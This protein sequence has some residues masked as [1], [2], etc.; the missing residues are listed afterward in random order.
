MRGVFS[1]RTANIAALINI[2]RASV[3]DFNLGEKSSETKIDF[4]L[5]AMIDN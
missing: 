1:S 3:E 4:L 2:K 5:G